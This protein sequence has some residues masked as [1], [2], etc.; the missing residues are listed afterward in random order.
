MFFFFSLGSR[1]SS[2]DEDIEEVGLIQFT[3]NEEDDI[4]RD[5]ARPTQK[6]KFRGGRGERSNKSHHDQ[7]PSSATANEP[8][9]S[10]SGSTQSAHTVQQSHP[11]PQPPPQQFVQPQQQCLQQQPTTNGQILQ[12]QYTPY[13]QPQQPLQAQQLPAQQQLAP[14]PPQ[15]L[16][17]QQ[18]L[19]QQQ[20]APQPPQPLQAQQLPAQ[21][22]LAPQPP[23]LMQAQQFSAQQQ[24]TYQQPQQHLQTDPQPPYPH[25]TQPQATSNTPSVLQQQVLAP[26]QAPPPQQPEPL[27]QQHITAAHHPLTRPKQDDQSTSGASTSP[28][29]RTKRILEWASTSGL[30]N[31]DCETIKIGLSLFS[32]AEN[33]VASYTRCSCSKKEDGRRGQKQRPSTVHKRDTRDYDDRDRRPYHR[34]Y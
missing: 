14:Q 17:A 34:R 7:A 29:I 33:I 25:Y 4:T 5:L 24:P 28:A 20:L 31:G 12:P 15:P 23:Q 19:A 8:M 22:Q 1:R 26:Q 10:S 11:A 3:L 18:L 16:Q 32:A 21:Q 27:Q 30:S 2:S 6:D 13:F 9:P